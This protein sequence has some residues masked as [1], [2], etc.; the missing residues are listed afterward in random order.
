MVGESSAGKLQIPP[1]LRPQLLVLLLPRMLCLSEKCECQEDDAS[2][3]TNRRG[4]QGKRGGRHPT[5]R[6]KAGAPQL[7]LKQA[8][9]EGQICPSRRRSLAAGSRGAPSLLP[10][11]CIRRKAAQ[12]PEL[13]RSPSLPRQ[14]RQGGP[15]PLV[16][17]K[18]ATS[19]LP[20]VAASF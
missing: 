2:I 20:A 18:L 15:I 4:C 16:S 6:K 5:E 7:A 13:P 17:S 8:G 1:E 10:P 12:P 3:C 19:F 11:L 14:D 9:S